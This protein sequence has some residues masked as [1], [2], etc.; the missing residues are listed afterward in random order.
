MPAE[1]IKEFIRKRPP[2]F[3]WTLANLLAAA[4]AVISWTTCLYIFNYPEKPA[5]Y[6]I[7]RSLKRLAPVTAFTPADA[8]DGDPADPKI[9]FRK[10]FSLD[11]SRLESLNLA[12][13]RDYLTNYEESTLLTYI[14]G[15]FI[16]SDVEQ[17]TADHI[18]HPGLAI[19]AQATVETGERDEE[20][21]YPVVIE[22]LLP[23]AESPTETFFKKGDSLTLSRAT[24]RAAV[25]AVTKLGTQ[26]KPLVCLTVV[27]LSSD[28]YRAPDATPLP[29]SP[30]D[31]L[32]LEATFPVMQAN[33]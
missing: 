33:R 7:L 20:A 8:P 3:W 21:L 2:F 25:L 16:V 17:L 23:T 19:R 32:N 30:P 26:E 5:N 18:F 22:L 10:F 12:Q 31:P 11:D 27:P 6:E 4:F 24:H 9:A 14:E 15:D 1:D 29:L 28:N 13:K